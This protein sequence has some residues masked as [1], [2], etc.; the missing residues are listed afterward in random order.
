[1]RCGVAGPFLVSPCGA[2]KQEIEEEKEN[3]PP[4]INDPILN[5]AFPGAITREF[6][7][8][9]LL[10]P[11]RPHYI[12]ALQHSTQLMGTQLLRTAAASASQS[13][14]FRL[15]QP[16]KYVRPS[17][18]ALNP[19]LISTNYGKPLNGYV[20]STISQVNT[21]AQVRYKVYLWC[22]VYPLVPENAQVKVKECK[23][24]EVCGGEGVNHYTKP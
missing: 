8:I 5:T 17:P 3:V 24:V 22:A 9:A 21:P 18:A 14:R 20:Q 13:S 7:L 1:M 23:I 6:H 15:G 16:V 4:T 2:C 19:S 11:L 12:D 10:V